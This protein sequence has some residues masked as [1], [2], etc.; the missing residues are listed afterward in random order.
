MFKN[1]FK[2]ALRNAL[3][4][5]TYSIISLFSLIL[6]ITLFFLITIWVQDELSYDKGFKWAEQI[7]RVETNS[8]TKDGTESKLQT[9]G[10][11]VGRIL[12]AQYPEI[13]NVTYLRDWSPII[14]FRGIHF[15]E[16]AMYAD[17]NFFNVFDYELEK[18]NT[19]NAL[20]EPNSLIISKA[21]AEKYFNKQDALGKV[22]MIND[23]IPYKITGVLKNLATPSHL[24]FDMIGSFTSFCSLYS[25]DCKRAYESGWFDVNV[26]NYIKLR[27]SI[28]SSKVELKIKDIILKN[29]KEAVAA[30]GFKSTLS[31]MP[32]KDIYLRSGMPTGKG[33]V[34]N[35]TTVKLFLTIGI[36]IL[37]I[38]CLNFIN[39]T[40]SKSVDRAK[41]IGIKKVLG[42]SRKKLIIQFLTETALL[43]LVATIIGLIFMIA[44]LPLFNQFSEKTFTIAALLSPGNLLLIAAII[45]LLIPIAGLYPAFVLSSF[46]P[47]AVLKGNFSHT[48][49]GTLL[50]KGLV[51]TQF[52]IS[53]AFILSTIIIWKQM[54]FM[55][56]QN[57]GFDKD[58][59]LVVDAEKLPW[60]VRKSKGSLFKSS[61]LTQPGIKNISA[62]GAVPGRTGWGSQFAWPE[63]QPKDAQLIVEYI[64]VDENY[65][66]TLGLQFIKGRDFIPGSKADSTEALIINEAAV[67]YF[68]WDN[69]DKAIGKKLSTSGKDGRIIGVLKNYHQH[70]LQQQIKPVVLGM[71]SSINVFA[72]RYEGITPR[73]I[74]THA[75]TAWKNIYSGYPIEYRFMDE[76]FQQQYQKEE[77]LQSLFVIAALL[78]I[79][80]ACMG[81]FGLAIYTAQKRIKE[82]GVRKVLGASA[83]GIA[84]LLS[85][86]FL[87]LVLIAFVVASPIAW[88]AM[89][90]WLEYFAYR[91]NISWW[92]FAL[93]GV[94]AMLIAL[95]TISFQ[96]IKA[97]VANPVKNLRTE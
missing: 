93:T 47:V 49:R 25:E 44:L 89:D 80:I 40:T 75:Q 9:V 70:G 55:Q 22:L 13:E 71:G 31:L 5:L 81:L 36:F 91:I 10:W 14:N 73:Q 26:Y 4:N 65:V 32:V 17:S 66:K 94:I 77:K 23:T 24:R 69:G 95:A 63:G 37:I 27:K 43:C 6:G 39:L 20:A 19:K 16:N 29:G 11:P 33:T 92:L 60:N 45:I 21:L 18:G 82:I 78:S 59:L 52:V 61:L 96:A 8:T 50:R 41:E 48:N 7:F 62:C 90:K 3:K 46:K 38:A 79:G 56:D 2:I 30:T 88:L 68:G 42:S 67:K 72:I 86:D 28:S 1:Y 83:A 53:I 35:I 76:D 57:L 58:K 85:K 15:Y 74:T 64:P 87:K 12:S 54:V 34:G 84:I 51:V 97:A